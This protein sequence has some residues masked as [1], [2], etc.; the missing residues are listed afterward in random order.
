MVPPL[1]GEPCQANGATPPPQVHRPLRAAAPRLIGDKS[2]GTRP[3]P[4]LPPGMVFDERQP[5]CSL[6]GAYP[7]ADS[8]H[9]LARPR[10]V[11]AGLHRGLFHCGA[12]KE[13]PRGG[14]STPRLRYSMN[15]PRGAGIDMRFR[16]CNH[17]EA[18]IPHFSTRVNTSECR[19][20][21][22]FLTCPV[23]QL[24]GLNTPEPR[25][26]YPSMGPP[27]PRSPGRRGAHRAPRRPR[28]RAAGSTRRRCIAAAT[29][30][31]T[32]STGTAAAQGG[33][34]GAPHTRQGGPQDAP[35][36]APRNPGGGQQNPPRGTPGKQ[37]RT[38]PRA[39]DTGPSGGRPA[40]PGNRQ[41][42]HRAERRRAGGHRWRAGAQRVW[43]GCC[44]VGGGPA[45]A[46]TPRGGRE[47]RVCR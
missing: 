9:G 12:G 21:S 24:F 29:Q 16:C 28:E 38:A 2:P 4:Q 42:P 31:G 22:I 41:P 14:C 39:G 36:R 10:P 13:K 17:L 32:R 8:L 18:R 20:L 6:T 26:A 1:R 35:T 5:L 30:A 25:P 3:S 47:G 23:C 15:R 11:A 33:R 7:R 44:P 37:R 27:P 34:A 19:K 45:G 43:G 40:A 46:A